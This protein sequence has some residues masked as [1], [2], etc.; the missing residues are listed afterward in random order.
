MNPFLVSARFRQALMFCLQLIWVYNNWVTLDKRSGSSNHLIKHCFRNCELK[1]NI[2]INKL[3]KVPLL[4]AR[5]KET[6]TNVDMALSANWF[7]EKELRP[8]LVSW[9]STSAV[10]NKASYSATLCLKVKRISGCGTGRAWRRP[11][12]PEVWLRLDQEGNQHSAKKQSVTS[13]RKK[14]AI[15]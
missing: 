8:M 7:G 6:V 4:L 1:K 11:L 10:E 12:L 3:K 9:K 15:V 13:D 14:K 2:Y 5:F